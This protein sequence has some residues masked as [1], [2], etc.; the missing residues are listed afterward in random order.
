M[1]DLQRKIFLL[2]VNR[3]SP[4]THEIRDALHVERG[5]T[6]RPKVYCALHYLKAHH[7]FWI[8]YGKFGFKKHPY[9]RPALISSRRGMKYYIIKEMRNLALRGM[10]NAPG[11]GS[12]PA[13]PLQSSGQSLDPWTFFPG[14]WST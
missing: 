9:M 14:T 10:R 1:T 6:D 13:V 5:V 2:W 3:I 12:N 7:I 8:E 11:W 4:G